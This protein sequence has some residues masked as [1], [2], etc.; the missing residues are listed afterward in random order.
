MKLA[1]KKVLTIVLVIFLVFN[2]LS[3]AQITNHWAEENY[4]YFIPQHKAANKLKN[5]IIHFADARAIM[6]IYTVSKN[7]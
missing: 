3:Y 5:K 1:L 6:H 4:N 7:H 2:N